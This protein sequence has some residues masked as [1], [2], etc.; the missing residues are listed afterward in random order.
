MLCTYLYILSVRA[1]MCVCIIMPVVSTGNRVL[2]FVYVRNSYK[3]VTSQIAIIKVI[4]SDLDLLTAL[5][6][7]VMVQMLV[8]R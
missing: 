3:K 7:L 6:L 5:L 8:T 2:V 1:H 4:K